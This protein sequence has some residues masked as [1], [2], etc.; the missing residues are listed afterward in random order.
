[1]AKINIIG[2]GPGNIGALTLEAADMMKNENQNFLRTE[3]HPSVRYMKNNEIDYTSYDFLYEEEENFEDVYLKISRE[4]IKEAEKVNEINYFVPGHP[5]TADATVYEIIKIAKQ[6]NIKINIIDSVSFIDAISK[7]L[8]IDLVENVKVL[9]SLRLDRY[10]LDINAKTI[11][12]QVYSKDVATQMKLLL[13]EIY[14]DEHDA[15]VVTAP[16]VEELEEIHEVKLYELDRLETYNH[17]TSIFIKPMEGEERDK[18]SL[19]DLLKIMDRLRGKDGCPWDFEQTH[20]SLKTALIEEAYEVFDA[21]ETE[22]EFALEEELGDLLFQIV[23]HS[24]ISSEEGY[25][26]MSDVITGIAKKM[27]YRHP[28]V[29]KNQ[30]VDG[31]EEVLKNWEELKAKEKNIETYTNRLKSI[32]NSMPALMKS[33]KIQSKAAKVGFDWPSIDGAYE[34]VKEELKELLE[35]REAQSHEEQVEELGDLI[36]AIVNV[37]RFLNVNPEE[38]LNKTSQKF[39]KRFEYIEK[40]ADSKGKKLEDMSLKEMDELWE[41][42]KKN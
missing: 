26:D 41:E 28:H 20:E 21:I 13:S 35:A 5:M 3:R 34:K 33:F 7:A 27:I 29:F 31:S 40:T 11:I 1:M 4:V 6:K 22:D 24:Q 18:Y 23:F 2:L 19:N 10:M 38:A 8:K 42:A 14:S 12:T 25:F 15:I 30:N 32:P 16:G 17:L 9:D 36:F 39:I 37:A